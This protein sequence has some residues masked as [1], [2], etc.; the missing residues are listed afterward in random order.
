MDKTYLQER[1]H[2]IRQELRDFEN[3][4]PMTLRE[5]KEVHKWV[6]DGNRIYTNPWHWYYENGNGMNYPDALRFEEELYEKMVTKTQ[7][8]R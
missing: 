4:Y 1:K 5:K 7:P 3:T 6:S 2:K 8:A